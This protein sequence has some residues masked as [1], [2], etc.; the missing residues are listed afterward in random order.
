MSLLAPVTDRCLQDIN[1]SEQLADEWVSQDVLNYERTVTA[2]L[3]ARIQELHTQVLGYGHASAC[4]D[5]A[6]SLNK[7]ALLKPL[8]IKA[9]T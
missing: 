9:F 6:D 3:E 8:I 2:A 5:E 4:I 7:L 1:S